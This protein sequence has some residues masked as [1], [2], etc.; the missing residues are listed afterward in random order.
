MDGFVIGLS[1]GIDSGLAAALAVRAVGASK[2]YGLSMPY[3]S[4]STGSVEHASLLADK[5]GIEL[6]QIAITPMVEAY[7]SIVSES[8]RVRLGNKMARERM[9]ILFDFAHRLNR[10]V[11]GTGNRTE[12]C[13]GYTTLYGDSACSVNPIG[14]LYKSEVRQLARELGVPDLIIDK[15]PSADLWVDQTDEGEIGVT[16]E[17]IDRM[18]RRIVDDGERS[19]GKLLGEGFRQE[20][21]ERVMGML[22]KSAFKRNLPPVAPLGKKDIPDRIALEA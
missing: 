12:A 6:R 19:L 15:A 21:I 14:Q 3:K 10:L 7:Y 2:V 5:L 16:Y 8:D 9:S 13:L 20:D 17:E 22:N 1:G 18:L 4:S 11:L